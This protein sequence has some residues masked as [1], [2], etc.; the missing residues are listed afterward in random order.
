MTPAINTVLVVDD[1]EANRYTTAHALTR[2]G[3]EVVEAA[4]GKQALELSR[5]QPT[6]IV[7]DV[8]LPDILGYEVCRRIK[9]NSHTRH[10]PVLQLSAAFL[11]NESKLFA[12]ES[13]ADAYLWFDCTALNPRPGSQRNNGR[14][15][16]TPSVKVSPSSTRTAS[17]SDAIGP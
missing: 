11:S 3:F 16:S 8:K 15:R 7:L 9:A 12:L 17:S 6:V 10:I 5:N 2:A 4:T 13:G 1:R 14:P